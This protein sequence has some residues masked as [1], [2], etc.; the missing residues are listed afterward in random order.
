MWNKQESVQGIKNEIRQKAN[1][2]WTENK[3]ER[4]QGMKW[5]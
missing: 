4:G 5:K 2:E 3:P 1:E